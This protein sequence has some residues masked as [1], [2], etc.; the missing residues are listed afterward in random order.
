MKT[1]VITLL[2]IALILI[3]TLFYIYYQCKYAKE[4]RVNV[5]SDKIKDSIKISHITDFHSNKL[6]NMDYFKEK[7][8]EFKPDF[9]ILTG[10]IND[11]GEPKKFKKALDFLSELSKLK[12]KTYYVSGNH[13]EAG[14]MFDEFIEALKD[15]SIIY[16]KNDG[17]KLKIRN[18][19][20]YIY[21]ISY[22][23]YSFDKF[24]PSGESL[25]IILSHYSK[26]VRDNIDEEMDIIFSGHTHGGQVRFPFVGAL[27]APEE[28]YLP[29][30]DK[31]LMK[32]KKTLIYIDSGLGN[33][34][35]D[36]RFLNRVQ[37][38]NI[39]INKRQ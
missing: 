31:G 25:N 16:L 9:I 21:G 1:L 39:K 24:N 32:Y 6:R 29:K 2:L 35:M 27:Y 14:P 18:E 20:V 30:F 4:I 28:G 23:N 33:T 22:Y 34:L 10:D 12:I 19:D 37:F 26:N 38:S 11:Y 15:L 13:E 3:L 5:K 7:I 36:L 8:L 17:Q